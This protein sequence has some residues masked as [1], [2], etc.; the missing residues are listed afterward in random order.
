L[1]D[2]RYLS[3][4]CGAFDEAEGE[5][6]SGAEEALAAGH[7]AGVGLMVVSGEVEQAVED[8]DLDFG[9]E[10]VPLSCGLLAGGVDGDG[11]VAG[12]LFAAPDAW[13]WL[14][15]EREDV[16]GFVLVAEV[17]V[18]GLDVLV[19]GEKD[20]DCAFESDGGLRLAEVCAERA[21]RGQ[22]LVAAGC[23]G[24]GRGRTRFR[25]GSS[26]G[27]R[28]RCQVWVEEDHRARGY[29]P[30]QTVPNLF[31]FYAKC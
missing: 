29:L 13:N 20:A 21:D 1:G 4:L 19:G 15:G 22:A 28:V 18:E 24:C 17:A 12:R 27:V 26:V 14:G 16:G 11:Q 23:V 30:R 2:R 6:E 8:E 25:G 3:W 9:G 5:I 31:L 10:G 7:L